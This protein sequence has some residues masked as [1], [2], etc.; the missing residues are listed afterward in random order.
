MS[1]IFK[2]I[3]AGVFCLAAVSYSYAADKAADSKEATTEE[4]APVKEGEEPKPEVKEGEE[5]P[6]EEGKEP[7]A[8]EEQKK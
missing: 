1:N 4:K 7:A 5:K 3:T 6:A 2:L 8:K